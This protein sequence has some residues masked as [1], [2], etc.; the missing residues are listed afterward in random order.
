MLLFVT[1][2]CAEQRQE[3]AGLERK[4]NCGVGCTEKVGA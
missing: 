1:H 2:G 3:R 4:S